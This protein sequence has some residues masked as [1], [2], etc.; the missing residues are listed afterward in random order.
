MVPSRDWPRKCRPVSSWRRY[1]RRRKDLRRSTWDPRCPSARG[2]NGP[3]DCLFEVLLAPEK[4]CKLQFYKVSRFSLF[5]AHWGKTQFLDKK[6]ISIFAFMWHILSLL[7][8]GLAFAENQN[9]RLKVEFC[10]TVFLLD[11]TY[12][13]IFFLK[14]T[15]GNFPGVLA[16]KLSTNTVYQK[17]E[18]RGSLII[19]I[20]YLFLVYWK[21]FSL[22]LFSFFMFLMDFFYLII[23]H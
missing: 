13:I 22:D 11:L 8:I 6:L 20:E 3:Q 4:K 1:W 10:P 16:R 5:F 15:V 23:G 14:D 12:L 7:S 2:S 18:T 21:A 9:S 17:T 19:K